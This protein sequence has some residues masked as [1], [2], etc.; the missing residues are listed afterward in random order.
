MKKVTLS[1]LIFE[2][3]KSNICQGVSYKTDSI[4]RHPIPKLHNLHQSEPFLKSEY[5]R[6]KE[7]EIITTEREICKICSIKLKNH[8][9]YLQ[10]QRITQQQP[11][12]ANAPLTLTSP[13]RLKATVQNLRIENKELS[14]K[15]QKELEKNA[16]PTSEH[17]SEDLQ[18]IMSNAHPSKVSDF[19]QFFWDE[20]QHYLKSSST[21]IRYHP[22][23]IRYCL[24]LHSKSPSAYEDIRYNPKTGTGFLILPS[25]RRLRD[26]RNYIHPQ[27]GFNEHIINELKNKVKN[28]TDAEKHVS[29]LLD[30]MKIQ[31]NLVWDKHT[32]EL[33]GYVDLG[34]PTLNSAVFDNVE[35]VATHVLVL[36]VRGI[37]NPIKFSLANFATTGA[38]SS[39]LYS[40][41]WKAV[42]ILETSCQLKVLAVTCDGASSN[43]KFFNMH[44]SMN[45]DDN[46]VNVT[47][48]IKN[49]YS[50]DG[51]RYI[52]FIADVPHLIKTARNCLYNSGA[53]K[54]S[55]YMWKDD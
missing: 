2:V 33:I 15:L 46:D 55:R 45:T 41:F 14:A 19:M 12:K 16:I 11:V 42:G 29:L 17:L 10:K 48:K 1:T 24:S 27:R 36:M 21:G 18:S 6:P 13:E 44:K 8:E 54:M 47:H 35:T 50:L 4:Q 38:N 23:I 5:F 39:Q 34:E 9:R 28:F 7:C 26:F 20:Q 43:R 40:I 53:G 37:I 30:E 25:Q 52:H 3:L 51:K 31:E 49:P 32:G 22:S